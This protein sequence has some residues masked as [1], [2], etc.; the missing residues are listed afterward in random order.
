MKLDT[1]QW[2]DSCSIVWHSQVQIGQSHHR[3]QLI[4]VMQLKLGGVAIF[5]VWTQHA[6]AGTHG[7]NILNALRHWIKRSTCFLWTQWVW[8]LCC[9]LQ[10]S[11][12]PGGD[13]W[14]LLPVTIL[15]LFCWAIGDKDHV[16]GWLRVQL[17]KKLNSSR[18]ETQVNNSQ[19][20]QHRDSSHYSVQRI[21]VS[22]T[23]SEKQ[24]VST[25]PR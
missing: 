15:S 20:A 25:E 12:N 18:G 9:M 21:T 2:S 3:H 7:T 1:D 8:H 17:N 19:P 5:R 22:Q 10:F 14:L 4:E 6:D 13:Y 24:E 11:V 23:F 16:T